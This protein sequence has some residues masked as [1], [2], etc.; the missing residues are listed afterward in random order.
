MS[1]NTRRDLVRLSAMAAAATTVRGLAAAKPRMPR[2]AD[3]DWPIRSYRWIQVAFTEDDPGNYDPDFWLRYFQEIRAQGACLSAGGAIAFYPTKI[4]FHQRSSFLGSHDSF[5]EMVR[6]C[7]RLGMAVIGRI[8]PHSINEAAFAAHPEWAARLA[9]GSPMR[10]WADPTRYVT[11]SHGPYN[12]EFMPRVIHEIVERYQVD[13]IFGNRWDGHTVCHCASCQQLFR[14]ATGFAIPV[15]TQAIGDPV[16]RA[17][18]VWE[19]EHLYSLIDLW[20][21]TIRKVC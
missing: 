20:T 9:D 3:G 12:F 8:D 7:R 5:G 11:C 2:P 21:A 1:D 18:M 19:N 13:A 17:N 10:H 6:G 16:R 15:E 14:A 4:P